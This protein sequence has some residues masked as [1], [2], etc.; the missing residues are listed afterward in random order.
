MQKS[1]I[2]NAQ[3][4]LN[5]ALG[6]LN[7]H[8]Q[9]AANKQKEGEDPSKTT[10]ETPLRTFEEIGQKVT[11]ALHYLSQQGTHPETIAENIA[12]HFSH[13]E[14]TLKETI[15]STAKKT[16]AQAT[17]T[18]EPNHVREIQ[19]RNLERKVQ[20]HHKQNK[21]DVVLTM[22]GMDADT[23]EKL[24][25]H[26][27]ME[28]TTKLQQTVE[29]QVKDNHPII[30]GIEKLKSQDIRI[31]CNTVNEAEQLRKLNWDKA[32]NGLT[33]RRP[34]YGIHVPGVPTNM[35]NPNE[36]Q[37]PELTRELECQNKENGLEIMEMKPM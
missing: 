12:E 36:T 20:Q 2:K 18:P 4:A 21:L 34:K 5:I 29:S 32:Y 16:Y 13:L 30:R 11:E 33:V 7:K 3:D 28:I 23:K 10:V 24:A 35:I 31:H 14:Q 1:P 27:H 22:K 37:N 9:N 15:V 25:Q 26:P 8:Y 6:H 17:A 19:Q